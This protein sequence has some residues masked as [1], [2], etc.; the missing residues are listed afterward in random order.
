M[1]YRLRVARRAATQI[2]AAADWWRDNR[3]KAPH[4]FAQDL[5][6]AFDLIGSFPSLGEAVPHARLQGVRRIYLGRIRYHLYYV[7]SAETETVDVLAL[8]HASRG[9]EPEL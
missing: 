8:W 4:A 3:S 9:T 6:Q 5:E 2:R 7:V 1:R